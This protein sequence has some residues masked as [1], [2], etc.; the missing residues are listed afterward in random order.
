MHFLFYFHFRGFSVLI[1]H[2]SAFNLEFELYELTL[3]VGNSYT[4]GISNYE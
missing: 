3:G 4:S 1:L 2:I